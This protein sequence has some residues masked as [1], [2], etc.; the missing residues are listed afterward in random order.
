MPLLLPAGGAIHAARVFLFPNILSPI[1]LPHSCPAGV[2]MI[3]NIQ[4]P[5]SAKKRGS[6]L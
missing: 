2:R 6:F 1:G 5:L 3:P 4:F